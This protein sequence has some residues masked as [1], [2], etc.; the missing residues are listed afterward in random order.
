MNFN[1]TIA[2]L[3]I[4]LFFAGSCKPDGTKNN[5]NTSA[6]N[7]HTTVTDSNNPL[8]LTIELKDSE[9]KT[10]DVIKL[11]IN[12]NKAEATDTLWLYINKAKTKAFTG[13]VNTFEWDTKSAKTG[14]N[15]IEIEIHKG[16]KRGDDEHASNY[17]ASSNIKGANQ[18]C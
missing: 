17:P 13:A 14:T 15:I 3:I 5:G 9:P 8:T 18:N 12:L 11:S 1:R 16:E 2:Y 4:I 10:G 6:D 7:G